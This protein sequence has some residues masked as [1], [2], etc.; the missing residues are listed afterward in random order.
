[1]RLAFFGTSDFS[2][3]ALEALIRAG[4]EIAAVYTQPPRK[5]ARGQ[6]IKKS[7]VQL[8]AKRHELEIRTVESLKG[9]GV[10]Q[11][12]ADLAVDAGVVVA[13]GLMLPKAFLD[14]PRLGCLN[15]HA[16]LLPRWR[17]AAPIQRALL[18]GDRETGVTIMVMDEG[19]DTGP[20]L[21]SRAVPIGQ[22]AT[23][24][25]L[26]DTLAQLGAEL[27]VEA[28]AGI[29]G[30][31]KERLTPRP[32]AAGRASYAP[33]LARAEGRIDWH[34]PAADLDLKVRAF[35]PWPGTWFEHEEQT[36]K[37][38]SA[39]VLADRQNEVP[40]TVTGLEPLTVACGEGSL[41]VD[42][43]QRPGRDAMDAR[44]FLRGYPI[45]VGTLLP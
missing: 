6:H 44:D 29:A 38:L 7:P 17:G 35:H 45:D 27:I 4:H 25:D 14:A 21:I 41:V 15:I 31:T 30:L 40:G 5:A 13:Y 22:R 39:H 18:A 32:Q 20:E 24:G 42:C 9:D 36:V 1:M 37:I 19:L 33:K 16:S 8:A 3:P 11:A 43:V 2:C 34:R 28:L 26:H 12:F 23:A 10:S